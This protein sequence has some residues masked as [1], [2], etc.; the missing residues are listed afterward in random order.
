MTNIIPLPD[1]RDPISL[2][3]LAHGHPVTRENWIRMN[4]A[5]DDPPDEW[6]AEHE[7]ELPEA[8]RRR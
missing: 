3:L 6:T 7:D 5:P 1:L 2:W 8:L 4:Y